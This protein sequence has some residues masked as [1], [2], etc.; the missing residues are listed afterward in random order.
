MEQYLTEEYD[1]FEDENYL[2][3]EGQIEEYFMDCGREFFECGQG[4]YDEEVDLICKIED[5]FY[6]VVIRAEIM[7]SKQDVGDRLYWVDEIR[8]VTYKEIEKPQPR[9]R[10]RVGYNLDITE[11]QQSNLEYFM[12]QNN[13]KFN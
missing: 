13:I 4:Y 6:V 3:N 9:E 10:V 2:T 5:K 11:Q 8:E 12:K 7:S 1:V